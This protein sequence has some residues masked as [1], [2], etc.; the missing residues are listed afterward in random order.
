MINKQK[1][2]V[3]ESRS[4]GNNGGRFLWKVVTRC[5][6]DFRLKSTTKLIDKISR[7]WIKIIFRSYEKTQKQARLARPTNNQRCN[8]VIVK[9]YW[10][11]QTQTE[12]P[13]F[14]RQIDRTKE[15]KIA[16]QIDCRF[17]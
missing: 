14:Y 4:G 7:S 3:I 6:C 17:L 9:F 8:D 11:L 16:S 13:T 1:S 5:A 2:A 15:Q 12:M 10:N